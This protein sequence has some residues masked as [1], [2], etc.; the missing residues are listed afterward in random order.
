MSKNRNSD[1]TIQKILV[2]YLSYILYIRLRTVNRENIFDI[3][4]LLIIALYVLSNRYN[5]IQ[6]SKY[7]HFKK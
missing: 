1:Q 5:C 4:L 6:I 7:I 3:I 2:I